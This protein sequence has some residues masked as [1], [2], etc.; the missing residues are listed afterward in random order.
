MQKIWHRIVVLTAIL[1][2]VTALT[3][4]GAAA[5]GRIET[6][7]YKLQDLQQKITKVVM[8]GNDFK[9]GAFRQDIV[10][11]WHISPFEFCTL[12]EFE[13]LKTDKNYYFLL[14]TTGQFS[15]EIEPGIDFLTFVKGGPEAKD[16]IG[17]LFEVVSVPL[18]TTGGT[19]REIA[20]L[21]ALIDIIQDFS[22]RAKERDMQGYRGLSLY[23]HNIGKLKGKKVLFA[24][25]DIA[26]QVSVLDRNK[27]GIETVKDDD[28]DDAMIRG[29]EGTVI[30]YTVA[31]AEPAS[32]SRCY[33]MLIDTGDH[34]LY[35]FK[36]HH[37]SGKAGAGFSRGDLHS[38]ASHN[39]K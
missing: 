19:G 28:A 12:Q 23:N 34:T 9:D 11:R 29:D 30:S 5:Q 36:R 21:P 16:G 3:G 26:L 10:P 2:A 14:I 39:K 37:I 8:T 7:K 25:G 33:K 38:I 31:P 22:L 6:K 20:V 24:E 32:G 4:V 1:A 17:E 27:L 18:G 13:Q 35:Y 15:G